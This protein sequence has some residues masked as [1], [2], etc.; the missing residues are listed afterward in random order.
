[1]DEKIEKKILK[2]IK[3]LQKRVD[4]IENEIEEIR[5]NLSFGDYD[6]ETVRE[7]SKNAFAR[8][9]ETAERLQNKK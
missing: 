5:D 9:Q 6:V 8:I 1:M 7:K 3:D 2:L 4:N